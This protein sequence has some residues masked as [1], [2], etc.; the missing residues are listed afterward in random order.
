MFGSLDVKGSSL[1][2]LPRCHLLSL[3]IE[4]MGINSGRLNGVAILA[5]EGGRM[6]F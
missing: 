6:G 4:S 3:L 1:G 2:I 5:M